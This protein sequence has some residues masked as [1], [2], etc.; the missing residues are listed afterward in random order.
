MILDLIRE[1]LLEVF[2]QAD[3]RGRGGA[4]N[5]GTSVSNMLVGKGK[6]TE[7]LVQVSRQ[8]MKRDKQ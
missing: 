5:L 7:Y 2:E 3:R 6:P 1:E 8:R 4:S